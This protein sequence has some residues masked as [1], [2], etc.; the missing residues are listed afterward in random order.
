MKKSIHLIAAELIR[1]A[2]KALSAHEI[3][4][5]M[6]NNKLYEFK[7]KSP[8]T[9]VRSQLRRHSVNVESKDKSGFP[10]FKMI[11]DKFELV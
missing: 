7:A 11:D 8:A 3:Y 9:V 10:L 4:E 5:L 2:G 1:A 6:E